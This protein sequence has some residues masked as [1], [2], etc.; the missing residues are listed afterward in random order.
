[1]HPAYFETL[2]DS[3]CDA[4]DWP[5]RFA[6]ITAWATTGTSWPLPE[7]EAADQRL[8]HEIAIRGLWHQRLIGYSPSTD[9]AESGWAVDL[10]FEVACDLGLKFAQD[11]I[12]F[13]E[14]DWLYVSYCD[15]RRQL[16]FVGMFRSRLRP[17]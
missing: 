2:F 4:S 12:Y 10:P 11:A 7:N 1:M 9:H 8:E 5:D 17:R 14:G 6:I 3:N 16:V 13:V 15:S